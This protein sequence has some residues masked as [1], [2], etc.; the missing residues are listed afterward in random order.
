MARQQWTIL[1]PHDENAYQ[2]LNE[3]MIAVT[4]ATALRQLLDV[5]DGGL[6]D[7]SNRKK[8]G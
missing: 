8:P 2:N 3:A 1:R 7:P 4:K 5:K 6:N